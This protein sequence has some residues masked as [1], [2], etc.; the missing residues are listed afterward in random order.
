VL[1]AH[2]VISEAEQHVGILD[3]DIALHPNFEVLIKAIN[4]E[5]KLSASA[6]AMLRKSLLS[7]TVD[8]LE[9]LKWLREYPEIAEEVIESPV[10]LTGLPRSGTTFFQYLFDRDPRFRLIRTWEAITP[11]PP[12]GFDAA[13][14]ITRK[15]EEEARRD[16]LRPKVEGFDALHLIDKDGSEECHA[17]L[18][19]GYGAAGFNNYLNV[20][21]YFDAL[22]D[23]LD[24]EAVYR[25][26]KRQLQ[27]LQWRTPQPRWALKY[28]NHVL[29]MDVILRVHPGARFVMTHRD[30]VQT[31]A[32]ISKMSLKL[33]EVR[34]DKPID[35]HEVGRNMLH[36][37]QRH[38][39]RI[40]AFANGPNAHTVLHVDYYAL[41]D[42]PAAAMREVHMGLGID[43]PD[44]VRRSVAMWHTNNPKGAR[45]A[46]P[47][48]LE[49]FGLD[50]DAVAT[51]FA[52]YMRRFNIP[53]EAQGLARQ[54]GSAQ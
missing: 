27:L 52:P 21:S 43:S 11:N 19:Q 17:F 50:G 22:L 14:V 31:L 32:S 1:S 35:P 47:Y 54:S 37:V 26:H 51:Q 33:R 49:Q 48:T 28:P 20:P 10:F 29:A 9:G 7:R 16:A 4:A 45:G 24:M 3:T 13:S 40:M 25:V 42:D 30:P 6:L 44:A 36:F 15:A 53:R 34:A 41:L 46:N 39:D 5:A 12:P 38:I 23:T 18:E 8:R 2:S